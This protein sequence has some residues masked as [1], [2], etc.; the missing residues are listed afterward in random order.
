M[1]HDNKYYKNRFRTDTMLVGKILYFT[2]AFRLYK[3]GDVLS[4]LFIKWHP[5]SWLMLFVGS[6]MFGFSECYEEMFTVSEYHKKKGIEWF[7]I[8]DK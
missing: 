8:W 6:F 1:K 7:S 3:N 5:I 2:G 4:I